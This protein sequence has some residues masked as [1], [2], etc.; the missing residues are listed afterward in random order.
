M[1]ELKNAVK[2]LILD[3]YDTLRY[4]AVSEYKDIYGDKASFFTFYLFIRS[5][6]F[7]KLLSVES[8]LNEV[9][10]DDL[11]KE[12]YEYNFNSL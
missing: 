2:N 3:I 7:Y 5:T 12:V 6:P 9:N 10:I 11:V 1:N 8:I 4:D